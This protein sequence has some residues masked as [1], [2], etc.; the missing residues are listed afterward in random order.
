MPGPAVHAL[1]PL[2]DLARELRSAVRNRTLHAPRPPAEGLVVEIGGGQ[3]PSPRADVVVDKYVIDSFERS[4]EAAVS[5]AKP[6]VVAD[7]HALPFADGSFAYSIASHVIEH[8][9]D[10]ERF[11]AELSR[12]SA[13]GFV[14]V[15]S[16]ESELT[17]G[18]P[19]HPW[20]VDRD[21]DELVFEP[22]GAARAPCG[23][24]FHESYA[25]SPLMR[26]WWQA[27]RSDWHHSLHWSGRLSIRVLGSSGAER[28][29]ELDV[30]QTVAFLSKA[31]APP[32]P[33]AVAAALRCPLCGE[34]LELGASEAV[35]A[36]CA[37]VYPVAGGVPVLL[38][39][40]ARNP[41]ASP[42]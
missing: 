34:R 13:A 37:R 10:P 30:G 5:L 11:A 22:K 42:Q 9:T 24:F 17:F 8:A 33:P 16:R 1:R 15:P 32:L 4:G 25:R 23:P 2:A 20:L 28:T 14:Q 18:W 36:G 40:A 27:Q 38:E 19:Y 31:G 12:V 6:L 41:L 39:E 21:G 26:L 35:C 3:A 29:A 7:G